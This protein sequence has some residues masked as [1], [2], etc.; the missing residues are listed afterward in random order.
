M[1]GALP[2][3]GRS[4]IVIGLLTAVVGLLIVLGQKLGLGRLPGDVVL[5]R[6]NVSVSFPIMT[7]IVISIVLTVLAN[8]FLNRR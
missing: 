5:E 7:S 1:L 4:L 3:L 2:H 6:K 8:V